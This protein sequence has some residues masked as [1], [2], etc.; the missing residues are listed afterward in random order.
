[1]SQRRGHRSARGPCS[2]LGGIVPLADR[3]VSDG[4]AGSLP[5]LSELAGHIVTAS[6]HMNALGINQGMSGN[7]SARV[8]DGF[9]VTPTSF[10]YDQMSAADVVRCDAAGSVRGGGRQSS[11]W[12]LHRDILASRPEIG[13]VVHAHPKSCTA[14]ALHGRSIPPVHYMV[15]ICGGPDIRCARY[16][17]FG[18]QELSDAVLVALKGRTA[19]LMAHHGMIALGETVDQALWRAVEVETLAAQYLA[20]LALGEPPHLSD[21]EIERVLMKMRDYAHGQRPPAET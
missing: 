16:E 4:R 20:S 18:T 17:T 11:E 13:A 15:A 7:I 8:A 14:L 2:S 12:R 9:L 19:C 5:D 10:P 1:M 6:R 21:E 3:Q